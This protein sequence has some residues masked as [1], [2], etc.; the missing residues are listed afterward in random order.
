MCFLH[1]Q[2]RWQT[3]L[4]REDARFLPVVHSHLAY[5][6]PPTSAFA[7]PTMASGGS[8]DVIVVGLGAAGSAAMYHMARQ[9]LSV[10]GLERHSIANDQSSSHGE[11]RIIRLAY[12]EGEAF[13][14]FVRRAYS[15]WQELEKEW[16]KQL[17]YVTGHLDTSPPPERS[18]E[19]V[20][21]GALHAAKAHGLSHE[22]LTGA[23][24]KV[25][26]GFP[27]SLIILSTQS[28]SFYLL[29]NDSQGMASRTIIAPFISRTA[30]F[31]CVKS[32]CFP[33][34]GSI[35]CS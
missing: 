18:R 3:Q 6:F 26:E 7:A 20:F 9:G 1:E 4:F 35:E 31:F 33:F 21:D 27:R 24:V 17:L 16:G 12:H 23:D 5:C 34:L 8:Y 13:V 30:G 19:G 32:V 14:P 28:R 15:L 11:T 10:L 22:V 2:S 29:R 25:I